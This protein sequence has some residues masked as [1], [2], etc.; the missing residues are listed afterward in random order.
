[1]QE[2]YKKALIALILLVFTNAL[3]ACLFVYQSFLT[4]SLL[5]PYSNGDRWRYVGSM[6]AAI[7]G[8]SSIRFDKV[9]DQRLAYSFSLNGTMQFPYVT[10][11]LRRYDRKENLVQIDLSKYTTISFVAK[12]APAN[13]LMFGLNTFDDKISRPGDFLTYPSPQ[14]YFFCNETGKPVSL[15]LTRLTIPD[16]WFGLNN[17]N[18]AHHEYN[19]KKVG[20]IA[21]GS[22]VHSPHDVEARVEISEVTLHGRD[23]R[24]VGA[25]AVIVLADL[26]VFGLW[27]FRAHARAL[28]A[29]VDSNLTKD[30]TLTAYR[31][32][33]LEPYKDKEK[34]LILRHISTNYMDA[35]LD[36]PGI[37]AATGTNRNKVN[38]VLKTELGMTFATYVNKLRLTEAARLLA[39]ENGAAVAEIAYT[40][41]YANVPYFNKLFKEQY[42]CTPKAFRA[43][44][45]RQHDVSLTSSP[46]VSPPSD[47]LAA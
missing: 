40:V 29:S 37:V 38:E 24:Y 33:T 16:W 11:E 19:L 8:A 21:F 28:M 2:F 7:G 31:Q 36:L 22:T 34:G 23:Y 4:L 41:G 17:S 39:Q 15:D 9:S 43:L 1:M 30:L 12:C 3:L 47:D 10:A 42:G 13:T 35:D 46:E 32:L 45:A 18:L 27:F 6:D 25:L 14:T 26:S 5:E 20:K 44:S